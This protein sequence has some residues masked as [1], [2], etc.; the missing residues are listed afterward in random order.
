M[1]AARTLSLL[2]GMCLLNGCLAVSDRSEWPRTRWGCEVWWKALALG[3]RGGASAGARAGARGRARWGPAL[4]SR[5]AFPFRGPLVRDALG[6]GER[7]AR[8]G[9]SRIPGGCRRRRD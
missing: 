1:I 5:R 9:R 2:T 8:A 4:L 6:G 7:A 3:V